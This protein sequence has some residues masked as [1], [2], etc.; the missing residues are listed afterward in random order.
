MLARHREM[1][2]LSPDPSIATAV[3]KY[4]PERTVV[5]HSHIQPLRRAV[6]GEH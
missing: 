3:T 6:I 4:H 1:V 2:N 5:R